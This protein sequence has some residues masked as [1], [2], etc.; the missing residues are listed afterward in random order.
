ML[1]ENNNDE[2]NK[3][4]KTVG[5][6]VNEKPILDE[7]GSFKSNAEE[8]EEEEAMEL[9]SG[10]PL[11][12]STRMCIW[13]GAGT[14]LKGIRLVEERGYEVGEAFGGSGGEV[15]A[16]KSVVDVS[17]FFADCV[18]LSFRIFTL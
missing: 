2:S 11:L 15:S 18:A 16:G 6:A 4:M 5:T 10:V 9:P 12:V 3:K 17:G 7:N 13:N 8:A 1:P 14:G